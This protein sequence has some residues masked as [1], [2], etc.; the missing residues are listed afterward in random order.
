MAARSFC[1]SAVRRC[2]HWGRIRGA[3]LT[4]FALIVTAGCG[5]AV[6]SSPEIR[7]VYTWTDCYPIDNDVAQRLGVFVDFCEDPDWRGQHWGIVAYY[8]D[9]RPRD[10][11]ALAWGI[12]YRADRRP[13]LS[14]LRVLLRLEDGTNFV[15][16][17]GA[18][19]QF[20]CRPDGR[21]ECADLV[22][23]LRGGNG[24]QAERVVHARPPSPVGSAR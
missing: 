8:A 17:S 5:G 6:W 21:S 23:T 18:R 13:D 1:W 14:G 4:A 19:P 12:W 24:S 11:L 3:G 10:Y 22:V 7:P 20:T 16:A 9:A 15:G 2:L